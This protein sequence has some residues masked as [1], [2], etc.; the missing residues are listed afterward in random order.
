MVETTI[1]RRGGFYFNISSS[2]LTCLI[3]WNVAIGLANGETN[4]ALARHCEERSN[5]RAHS[6]ELSK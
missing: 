6:A 2:S 1:A 3:F 4:N 5:G